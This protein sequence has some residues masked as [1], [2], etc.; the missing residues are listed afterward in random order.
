MKKT[1]Q[2]D[3]NHAL[4]F[5]NQQEPYLA[6]LYEIM[7]GNVMAEVCFKR[8]EKRCCSAHNS[9]FETQKKSSSM[10]RMYFFIVAGEQMN[11]L[12]TGL[13]LG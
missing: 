3:Q 8:G 10:K 2:C 1:I 6:I 13:E 12:H 11:R 9:L 7:G 4:P 5:K